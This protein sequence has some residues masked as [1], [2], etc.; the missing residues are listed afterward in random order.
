MRDGLAAARAPVSAAKEHPVEALQRELAAER[1]GQ[2]RTTAAIFGAGFDVRQR[3]D[4]QILSQFR[5]PPVLP[6]SRVGIETLLGVDEDVDF[7]DYLGD[8]I[9]TTTTLSVHES[10][11]AR[12]AL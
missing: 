8:P 3:M 2:M 12:L 5:R 7:T 9:E 10:M 1:S 4:A 11:E 6:S